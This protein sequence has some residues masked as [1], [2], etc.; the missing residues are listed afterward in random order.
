MIETFTYQF[1]PNLYVAMT[2]VRDLK[3]LI[4][5]FQS[6]PHWAID[7]FI[8]F[9]KISSELLRGVITRKGWRGGLV[10]SLPGC[11]LFEFLE[12]PYRQ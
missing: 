1:R 10:N 6:K 12:V 7:Y 8:H 9:F 5:T 2:V 4:G 3:D 11:F